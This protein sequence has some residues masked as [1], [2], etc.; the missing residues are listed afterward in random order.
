[1]NDERLNT[2]GLLAGGILH[3][4]SNPFAALDVALFRLE[5]QLERQDVQGAKAMLKTA[6]H[7]AGVLVDIVRDMRTLTHGGSELSVI[8]VAEVVR[9]AVRIAEAGVKRRAKVA[10]ELDAGITIAAVPGLLAQVVVNFIVNAAQATPPGR[11]GSIVVRARRDDALV[12][13]EVQDDGEGIAPDELAKIF[14]PFYTT[15]APGEGSGLG[16][17]L[18]QAIVKQHKGEIRVHSELGAG[19]TMTVALPNARAVTE[20]SDLSDQ[21][22]T[23]ALLEARR[24]FRQHVARQSVP[25][26]L[27]AQVPAAEITRMLRVLEVLAE[28]A[29]TC[30]VFYDL[31]T[32]EPGWHRDSFTDEDAQAFVRMVRELLAASP[33]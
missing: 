30:G 1:V 24:F 8:D 26:D 21:L 9:S 11:V 17:A 16:L 19:T 7:T 18:C 6:Q 31:I 10:M 3:E 28:D 22:R 32:L 12:L 33:G 4:I 2:L 23:R 5:D 15:K 27:K 14:E 25:L 20:G 29:Q 13:I